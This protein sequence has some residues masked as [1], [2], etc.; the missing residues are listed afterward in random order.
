MSPTRAW[1]CGWCGIAGPLSLSNDVACWNCSRRRDGYSIIESRYDDRFSTSTGHQAGP[2][3]QS[4]SAV[5]TESVDPRAASKGEA[6]LPGE[7][8]VDPS[9]A[10][11]VSSKEANAVIDAGNASLDGAP[12]E[13]VPPTVPSSWSQKAAS[14]DVPVIRNDP[15]VN[16]G[17]GSIAQIGS[18][19]KQSRLNDYLSVNPEDPWNQEWVVYAAR[20]PLPG[21]SSYSLET[22]EP[23]T[24][25]RRRP[26]GPRRRAEVAYTRN[27][28]GACS[29]CRR[30]HRAVSAV[31]C[32]Y[33]CEIILMHNL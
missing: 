18:I 6:T 19:D 8:V 3:S 20:T 5:A 12:N 22:G 30:M 21:E 10:N 24:T 2:H 25:S 31:F 9:Q 16:L 1:Y 27:N 32:H 7:S 23:A 26:Y 11:S 29:R 4:V 33:Q 14:S 17:K 15:S 28:G 13:L